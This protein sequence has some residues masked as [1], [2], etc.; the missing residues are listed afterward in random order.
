MSHT[1]K[2]TRL[3]PIQSKNLRQGY[4][5]CWN[6]HIIT[7]VCHHYYHY[8]LFNWAGLWKKSSNWWAAK[9]AS[10]ADEF[11]WSEHGVN[12]SKATG[13]SPPGC[14]FAQNQPA[15]QS[16]A[17]FLTS[18]YQLPAMT[19]PPWPFYTNLKYHCGIT[20]YWKAREHFTSVW[21][22]KAGY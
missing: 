6:H 14:R 18:K 7:S 16:Q 5:I 4:L 15:A 2:A 22:Y 12:E 19:K 8:F 17:G 13:P 10:V 20:K 9:E 3:G 11:S 21:T 1:F